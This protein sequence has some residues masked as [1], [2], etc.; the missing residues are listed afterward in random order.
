[1]P[2]LIHAQPPLEFV[3]PSFNPVVYRCAEVVL[4]FW[5]RWRARIVDVQVNHLETLAECYRRFQAG[6][7]RFM[8][9]F[10]HPSTNDP[11]CLFHMLDRDLSRFAQRQGIRLQVP[12]HAH[13]I[14]D[15]GIPLWAGKPVGWLLKNMG[16]TPIRRGK[17]DLL[18]LRS[19]REIFVAGRFPIAAAPEGATNG[20][21]GIVSPMEPGIAQLGFWCVEDLLKADRPEAVWIVPV[22]IQYRY[23]SPPWEAI[24][25]VLSHLEADC[26]LPP[27]DERDPDILDV[28]KH[29][30]LLKQLPDPQQILLYKRL[31]RLGEH[32]LS[33][34]EQFYS[35]FYHQN[36]K[37]LAGEAT[38]EESG[39]PPANLMLS[40][41]LKALLNASLSVAEE[42]F[43]VPP[44][45]NVADRCR[46]LEQAGWDRIFRED[47]KE[48]EALSPVDRGLADRIAEEASLRLWHMRLVESFVSV[49][50]HYILE[51]PTA[52]RFAETLLLLHDTVSK[53][54]GKTYPVRLRL[55][56]Q[57][58]QLTI[59]K[60]LSIRERW[61]DYTINRR[62]AVASL[63]Q[64]LQGA[65]EEMIN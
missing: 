1:M 59:G 25:H 17:L 62:Q 40:K 35:K 6:E 51:K 34:M 53:I 16:C 47:L 49:T 19:A 57:R 31:M 11:F 7:L 56:R 44:K 37:V 46:R 58:A 14:Y 23:V 55:G 4:P 50:G 33:S 64:D 21:S 39:M 20:H 27:I 22:G 42:Y 24:E 38:E 12:L 8:L 65:M 26:G 43:S 48:L 29:E 13:F 15:R 52:E 32:L 45:G 10:R 30:L 9:A 36:L 5:M 60:P 63:T 61:G 2:K 28:D 18:G 41:R 54:K 3:P